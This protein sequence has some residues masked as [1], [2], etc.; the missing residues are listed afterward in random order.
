[1]IIAYLNGFSFSFRQKCATIR[2]FELLIGKDLMI[3]EYFVFVS[4]IEQFGKTTAS[5]YDLCHFD[6]GK[7]AMV[8]IIAFG[9]PKE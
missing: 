1:M 7:Y 4:W 9:M 5:C 6:Y 2:K 8:K 3:Y